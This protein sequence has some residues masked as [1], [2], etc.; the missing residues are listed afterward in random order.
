MSPGF[1]SHLNP[2]C[3]NSSQTGSKNITSF[4]RTCSAQFY[5][6]LVQ[7]FQEVL[8]LNIVVLEMSDLLLRYKICDVHVFSKPEGCKTLNVV[9]TDISLL[10]SISEKCGEEQR[11]SPCPSSTLYLFPTG[12]SRVG[13]D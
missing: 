9:P 13:S 12:M 5:I 4:S 1:L 8:P 11:S 3:V 10:L 2:L 6:Y 7:H